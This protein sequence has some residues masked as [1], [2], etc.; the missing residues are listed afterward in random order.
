MWQGK[1][2]ALTF[3]FDDGI[4]QDRR[5]VE[6]LNKYG[7]KGTWNL[8][9]GLLSEVRS[10][11]YKDGLICRDKVSPEEAK[12]LYVGHEVA[13]HTVTHPDLRKLSEEEIVR[14]IEED[15]KALEGIFGYPICGMAYPFGIVNDRE[16]DVVRRTP[17]AYARTVVSTHNFQPQTDLIRFNPTVHINEREKLFELAEKFIALETDEEQ[18]FYVWGHSYEM[19]MAKIDGS[20]WLSWEELEAFCKLIAGRADIFYGTNREVLLKK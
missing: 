17:I 12:S 15:K 2:K 7:L 18:I 20:E 4:I 1:N 9:S 14:E 6:L 16:V 19:D 3:S 10:V 8:N 11:P 5:V 13:V